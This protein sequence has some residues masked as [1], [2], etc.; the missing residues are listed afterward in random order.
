MGRGKGVFED[1]GHFVWHDS[2]YNSETHEFDNVQPIDI[3]SNNV[4]LYYYK[5]SNQYDSNYIPLQLNVVVT[6]NK[7]QAIAQFYDSS[8]QDDETYGKVLNYF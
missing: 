1:G 5:N 3:G 2:Q 7:A 6:L 4:K 8:W